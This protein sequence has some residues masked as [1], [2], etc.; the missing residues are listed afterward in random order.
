MAIE[1]RPPTLRQRQAQATRD[2]IVA[3][4]RRLFAQ[5]GYV[6][7]SVAQIAEE[8][9]VA[10][11]TVYKSMHTKGALLMALVDAIDDEA[12]VPALQAELAS[13]TDPPELVRACVKLTRQIHERC[14]DIIRALASAAPVDADAAAALAEG[15]R[16]HREGTGRL[17]RRLHA[18]GALRDGIS[19]ADAGVRISLL[20]SHHAYDEL[21][22]DRGWS[23]DKAAAW[24]ERALTTQLLR[25]VG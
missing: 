10:V 8:A 20:T 22:G 4:A 14:G 2:E 12:E 9:G 7:T 13:T 21:V 15:E 1:P 18:L 17:A 5:H 6:D 23:H 3:A 16:R 19:A 25:E 24:A 11:Q